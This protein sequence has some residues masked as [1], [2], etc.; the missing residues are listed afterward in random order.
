MEL[1]QPALHP[2]LVAI[3]PTSVHAGD[4]AEIVSRTATMR[5]LIAAGDGI[6]ELGYGDVGYPELM[7]RQA[8]D[9]VCAVRNTTRQREFRPFRDIFDRHLQDQALAAGLL[10]PNRQLWLTLG[11][12]VSPRT[13]RRDRGWQGKYPLSLSGRPSR[14]GAAARSP[15]GR[16]EQDGTGHSLKAGSRG[17]PGAWA[18]FRTG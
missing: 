6:A 4:Y 16:P 1:V 15:A 14:P 5:M 3:T 13:G 9:A 18:C 2:V 11:T 8:G 7:L 10:T 17:W 12:P